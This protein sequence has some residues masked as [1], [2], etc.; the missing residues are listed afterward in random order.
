M[1][2]RALVLAIAV[3]MI[4]STALVLAPSGARGAAPASPAAP[5]TAAAGAGAP[6]SSHPSAGGIEFILLSGQC[7]YDYC[8]V[9]YFQSGTFDGGYGSNILYFAVRDTSGDTSVNFTITDP[10]ATRD[11]VGQ[12][13]YTINVVLNQTTDEYWSTESGGSY[14][15]PASLAIGGGWNVT[16]SAPLGGMANGSFF[17]GTY[18]EDI[19]GSP[20]TDSV[21]LPGE[22]I[23]TAYT[24]Y[25][26]AN[27]APDSQIT[28]VSY[29]GTYDGPKGTTN[30]FSS[31]KNGIVTQSPAA[32]GSYSWVVPANATYDS[33][34]DLSVW[35]SIYVGPSQAE[36]ESYTVYYYVGEVWIE[37]FTLES[38]SGSACPQYQDSYFDSGTLIQGCAVVG[39]SDGGEYFT[40]IAGLDVSVSFWNGKTTVT[41]TGFTSTNLVSNASGEVSFS[42]LANSTYFSTIGTAPFYN[43]VNLTVSDPGA[44]LV[45]PPINKTYSNNTFYLYPSAASAGVTVSLN[46]LAYFEGQPVTATWT[47]S[48]TDSG[49]TGPI[50]ANQWYL[51]GEYQ[52]LLSQGVIT[53]TASSGTLPL[54]FP[55]GFTGEFYLEVGA[56]NATE[57]FYGEVAGYV[58]A[59]TLTLTP[60]STTFTPG[61]T[62][63]VEAQA[64][65]ANSL[66]DPVISYQIYADY[67]NG[68]TSYG[69]GGSVGTG[70]VA[71]GSSISIAVPSTGA[72]SEYWVYAYLG[73][74]AGTVSSAYLTLNQSW[75]YNIF[76]GV[77]TQSSYSDGSYQ[78]GQTVTVAFSIAP[79]GN[80]PLPVLYTFVVGVLG[81]QLSQ[82]VTTT[83]T[84]G[85]FQF[86]I[87]SGWQ[88]GVAILQAKLTGTYLYGNS[89]TGGFCAGMTAITINAHPSALS[90]ELGAGS[91]LTVGWLILLIIV[92]VL[93]LVTL[94]LIRRRKSSPPPSGAAPVTTPMNPPAPAPSQPAAQQWQESPPPSGESQPPMPTPPPG[95]T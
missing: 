14:T 42:F 88:T 22:P 12:P 92:I 40:A 8:N 57:L 49:S 3:L 48:S 29:Y 90:M 46:Q 23:T 78:P 24:A 10:N 89:C 56:S 74:S 65:G 16:F 61:S 95:A 38:N 32:Q 77:T 37:S 64:W 9:T 59:P 52:G 84:S 55:S 86:T 94:V 50:T 6:F 58:M 35:V 44:S 91:G 82:V 47:V 31:T 5:P 34:I 13:A 36:N 30:L 21:V 71:N 26:L 51:Y 43:S 18:E 33:Y 15:I 79:Y 39:G 54:T 80:A 7:P 27:G 1:S 19:Y 72:P 70:T 66:T 28:N 25:S 69:E 63:T 45:I 87:P 41:P 83:S 53:S 67:G 85:T 4:A 76:L 68:Y 93:F 73:S 11:H 20:Y 17:V 75:G 2:R 62:V 81:T 60:S